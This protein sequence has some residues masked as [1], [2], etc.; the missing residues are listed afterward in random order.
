VWHLF[1][2]FKQLRL[3][4]SN[5]FLGPAPSLTWR[6]VSPPVT[7][8]AAFSKHRDV[9]ADRLKA[10]GVYVETHDG[11]DKITYNYQ[12]SSQLKDGA[13]NYSCTGDCTLARATAGAK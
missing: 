13:V 7:G 11:G 2:L 4:P 3:K 12:L 5:P 10:W 6:R 8:R 9:T 1:L